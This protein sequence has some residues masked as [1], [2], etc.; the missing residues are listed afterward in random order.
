M[1]YLSFS[2]LLLFVSCIPSVTPNEFV[3]V[4]SDCWNHM[5]VIK[6]GKT[7]PRLIT[8]CDRK[9]VL[10]AYLMDG[11]A[12][13]PARFLGDVKGIIKFDYQYE[14]IDAIK[15]V[16]SAKFVTS[17]Q[18]DEKGVVDM[19]VLERAENSVIDK[20]IKDVTRDYIPT[21]NPVDIEES[22]IEV[23]ILT[24]VNKR[25][26]ERGI[27]LSTMSVDVDFKQ[28]TEQALDVISAYNLYKNAGIPEIGAKVIEN[29]AGKPD[30]Q[31]T[32]QN[33]QQGQ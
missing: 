23:D 13:V 18:T 14:I 6:A 12:E 25:L 30:L 1:K 29:Q 5:E 22:K 26:E 9:I 32:V 7:P 16:S 11:T 17:S 24:P 19:N 2:F 20:I 27:V 8:A 4:T 3:V 21:V 33:P 31:V 28:Q 10:P 15:F